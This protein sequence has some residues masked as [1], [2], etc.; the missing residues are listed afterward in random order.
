MIDIFSLFK[1][2]KEKFF[3]VLDIGTEALKTLIYKREGERIVVFG[4]YLLPFDEFS[5]FEKPIRDAIEEAKKKVGRKIENLFL[6]LP[7]NILKGRLISQTFKREKAEKKIDEREEKEILEKVLGEAKK[8]IS[9]IFSESSGILKEDIQFIN[10]QILETKIE[11]YKISSL[12]GYKGKNLD[13]RIFAT[14]LPK[15]YFENVRAILKNLPIQKIVHLAEGIIVFV[16]EINNGIFLDVGGELTQ[17]FLIKDGGLEAIDEFGIGGRI[18]SQSLSETFGLRERDAQ[19]LKE[20]YSKKE[21]SKESSDRIREIFS[22][23]LQNWFKNLKS[24]LKEFSGEKLLP[25]NFFLFGG[26]SSLPEI[27]EILETG[28]WEDI[29]FSNKIE[30]KLIYPKDLRNVKFETL[31][32]NNPQIIPSILLAFNF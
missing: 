11:G 17:I 25:S 13:F 22:F 23:P 18:F 31:V 27:Q 7:A 2:K 28:N 9:Q 8:R 10:F 29:V 16:K 20:R 26:G 15:F 32:L 30:T 4:S 3:L 21:F 5:P 14:F 6:T 12:L 19:I 24:K 1:R